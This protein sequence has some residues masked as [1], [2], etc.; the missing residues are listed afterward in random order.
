L[1]C[2]TGHHEVKTVCAFAENHNVKQ[3]IFVHH[4]KEILEEKPSV[5]DAVENCKIPVKLAH[6]GMNVEL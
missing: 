5:K 4:G 1:F 3:L 2:E 6:D